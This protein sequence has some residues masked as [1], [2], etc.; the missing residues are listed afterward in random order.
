MFPGLGNFDMN[1]D[2]QLQ[3]GQK[4]SLSPIIGKR[5]PPFEPLGQKL[6]SNQ[7]SASDLVGFKFYSIFK[8]GSF[9]NFVSFLW[10][11]NNWQLRLEW[12]EN[13]TL[14]SYAFKTEWKRRKKINLKNLRSLTRTLRFVGP[15]QCLQNK[16]WC[17]QDVKH[18][19][20][21]AAILVQSLLFQR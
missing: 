15:C 4:Q 8:S 6:L 11:K 7:I 21:G 19:P 2:H 9:S 18:Q 12:R 14:T 10:R 13:L 5:T 1:L 3:I 20:Y 17:R 16:R